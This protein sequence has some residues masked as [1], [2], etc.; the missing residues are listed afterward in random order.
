MTV[1]VDILSLIMYGASSAGLSWKG[2]LK[3]CVVNIVYF[4]KNLKLIVSLLI[5]FI[6][7]VV[8]DVSV[9]CCFCCRQWHIY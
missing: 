2:P 4:V 5:I 7:G 6:F 1:N 8:C 3:G 9:S